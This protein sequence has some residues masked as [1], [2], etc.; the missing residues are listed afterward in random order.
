MKRVRLKIH[1]KSFLQS[2]RGAVLAEAA[3]VLPL[4]LLMLSATTELGRFMYTYSTLTK[5]TRAS[6]RYIANKPLDSG[7]KTEA[8]NIAVYGSESST[9]PII[10][11]LETAA[12]SIP[13]SGNPPTVSVTITYAYTPIFG[14]GMEALNVTITTRT[15]IKYLVSTPTL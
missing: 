12:V 14:F 11:N 5:A 3:I 1:T 8:K 2:T 9:T 10:P 7:N 13:E 15:K 4:L 6:A